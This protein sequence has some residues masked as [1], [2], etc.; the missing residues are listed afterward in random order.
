MTGVE[1]RGRR[2]LMNGLI[3]TTNKQTNKQIN[4]QVQMTNKTRAADMSTLQHTPL[5]FVY[6]YY[7]H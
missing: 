4:Q 5:L 7:Y 6:Y 1:G 3:Y 2:M